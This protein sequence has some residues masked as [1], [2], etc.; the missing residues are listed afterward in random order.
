MEA[1]AS[2]VAM[3]GAHQPANAAASAAAAL[4]L[5]IDADQ[6]VAG[7]EAATASPGRMEIH[8]GAVTVVNDAPD[9]L[10][11]SGNAVEENLAENTLVG[12]FSWSDP[13][14]PGGTGNYQLELVN[15]EGK[16]NFLLD[17]KANKIGRKTKGALAKVLI[18]LARSVKLG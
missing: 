11:L 10:V 8:G 14:D 16:A 13:N 2:L 17:E 7:L 15:E 4:A 9:S 6:V 5:G 18:K 12:Q 1:S 3:A